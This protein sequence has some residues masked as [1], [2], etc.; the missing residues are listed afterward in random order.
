MV[1]T[2]TILQLIQLVALVLPANVILLQ[3]LNRLFEEPYVVNGNEFRP[4]ADTGLRVPQRPGEIELHPNVEDE[5]RYILPKASVLFF[6]F[7]GFA[8]L[9]SLLVDINNGIFGFNRP[10]IFVNI[11][12]VLF[13]VGFTAL[14]APLIFVDPSLVKKVSSWLRARVVSPDVKWLPGFRATGGSSETTDDESGADNHI[15]GQRS[16]NSSASE[17]DAAD[18]EAES[19]S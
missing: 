5:W 15:E 17:T 8:L 18:V 4:A 13:L 6:I 2:G 14:G 10:I 16:Q 3:V 1:D 7:A 11:A 19:E 12:I 9:L